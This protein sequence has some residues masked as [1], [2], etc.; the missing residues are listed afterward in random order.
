MPTCRNVQDISS[1]RRMSKPMTIGAVCDVISQ[2]D[3]TDF[4]AMQDVLWILQF[5]LVGHARNSVD[6]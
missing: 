5:H 6:N 4:V 3:T 1:R 2:N